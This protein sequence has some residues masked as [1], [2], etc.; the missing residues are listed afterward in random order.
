MTTPTITTDTVTFEALPVLS[1][2]G[3]TALA[4]FGQHI[5]NGA[6]AG[7]LAHAGVNRKQVLEA[8]G[9]DGF[10]KTAHTLSAGDIRPALAVVIAAWGKA[11]SPMSVNGRM[12]FAEW[13]RLG[14]VLGVEAQT[15][16]TGKPTKAAR[17]L[18]LHG[19]Y[20]EESSRL[21]TEREALARVKI[22]SESESELLTLAGMEAT[23][24][25]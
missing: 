14:A 15:T 21:R 4:K 25:A 10:K 18:A 17:A 22:E 19:Q 8:V 16:K 1:G 7:A 3:T 6:H 12:P 2:K 24:E 9:V 13:Q 23:S 20:S 11:Y 5:Q